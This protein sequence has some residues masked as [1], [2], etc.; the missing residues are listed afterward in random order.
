MIFF[1]S[2]NSIFYNVSALLKK[3]KNIFK[4]TVVE[5]IQSARS[6]DG[7]QH[8]AMYK[9]KYLILEAS[10]SNVIVSIQIYSNIK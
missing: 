5:S 3:K 2:F 7:H 8:D 10:P 6:A 1:S 4:R 9:S